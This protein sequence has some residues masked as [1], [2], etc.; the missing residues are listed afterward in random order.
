MSGKLPESFCTI[1]DRFDS[2]ETPNENVTRHIGSLDDQQIVHINSYYRETNQEYNNLCNRYNEDKDRAKKI[3]QIKCFIPMP[4]W[5]PS[6]GPPLSQS[7]K[8]MRDGPTRAI[9]T[10]NTYH[11]RVSKYKLV[12]FS[13]QECSTSLTCSS[14]ISI[15]LSHGKMFGSIQYLFSH[16]FC[17][18]S[19]VFACV[20]W[21]GCTELDVITSLYSV[22]TDISINVN[23]IVSVS[24]LIGPLI[25]A[26]IHKMVINYGF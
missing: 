23:P 12:K 2:E 5:I 16:F 21:Y 22:R 15:H 19:H 1:F 24:Q 14:V 4:E 7:E 17:T 3:H 26:L 13:S 18:S 9:E 20:H 6:S 25:T 10:F 11:H 8:M